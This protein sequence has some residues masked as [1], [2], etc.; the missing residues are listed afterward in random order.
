MGHSCNA[1]RSKCCNNITK[2]VPPSLNTSDTDPNNLTAPKLNEKIEEDNSIKCSL[3][4]FILPLLDV[5]YTPPRTNAISPLSATEERN[6]ASRKLPRIDG[7]E[8]SETT[9]DFNKDETQHSLAF[10]RRR[11]R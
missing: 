7:D 3:V 6:N 10:D 9:N 8:G 11:L 4:P 1:C 2:S 5:P